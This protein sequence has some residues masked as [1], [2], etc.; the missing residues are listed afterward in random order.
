MSAE[1]KKVNLDYVQCGNETLSYANLLFKSCFPIQKNHGVTE[2]HQK[3]RLL[4]RKHTWIIRLHWEIL[5]ILK[6]KYLMYQW[7]AYLNMLTQPCQNMGWGSLVK[8]PHLSLVGS[9]SS[10]V[11]LSP[12]RSSYPPE[13][14]SLPEY[15]VTQ[16]PR[17][18][19]SMGAIRSDH[20][21][22][23]NDVGI[24]I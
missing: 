14:T 22:L 15:W 16:P 19:C 2:G 5:H 12:N 21:L 9:Y 10:I 23:Q 1:T 13:M 17:C 6:Y 20:N 4:V 18:S 3:S 24:V 8:I 11:S 7:S